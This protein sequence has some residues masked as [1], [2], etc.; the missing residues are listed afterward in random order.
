MGTVLTN[1]LLLSLKMISKLI[2]VILPFLSDARI[3]EVS[4]GI[5]SFAP[6]VPSFFTYASLFAVTGEGVLAIDSMDT[7]HSAAFLE[8]IKKTTAEPIQYL[9]HTHNHWDH[10]G[11][12]FLF[13]EAGAQLVAHK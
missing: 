12:D 7:T 13:R 6:D 5:Y 1:R 3:L 10:N 4:D 2:F 9:V 11:G 8:D